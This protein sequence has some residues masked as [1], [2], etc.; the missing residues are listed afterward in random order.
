MI[1]NLLKNNLGFFKENGVEDLRENTCL[2][3]IV[4]APFQFTP[5]KFHNELNSLASKIKL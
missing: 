2:M 4:F 5:E 3:N 1:L